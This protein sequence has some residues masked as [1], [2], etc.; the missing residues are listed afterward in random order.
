MVKIMENP[1]KMDDLGV[2]P[3][4]LETPIYSPETNSK[5]LWKYAI[6]EGN[7]IF[8]PLVGGRFFLKNIHHESHELL[9]GLV[10]FR[11]SRILQYSWLVNVPPLTYP[12]QKQGLN[13]ALLREALLR[14]T[15][16]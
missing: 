4:F 1:I 10:P 15:N 5:S 3:I 9:H 14:E 6:P 11:V 16:G 8:E 2:F 7:L 13:K 12:P